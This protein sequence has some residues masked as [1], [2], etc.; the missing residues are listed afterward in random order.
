MSLLSL[1]LLF[2]AVLLYILVPAMQINWLYPIPVYALLLASVVTALLS[3]SRGLI[4]YPT[5]AV[6]TLITG[7]FFWYTLSGSRLDPGELAV[8]VGDPFPDFRLETSTGKF[9]S[10]MD[11]RGKSAGLFVFY[12]GDW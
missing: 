4:R 5:I 6:T 9:F 10:P 12:R 2:A 8:K 11:L 3:S 1:F 7:F